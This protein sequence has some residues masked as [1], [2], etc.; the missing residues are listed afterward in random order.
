MFSNNLTAE[1]ISTSNQIEVPSVQSRGGD[2]PWETTGELSVGLVAVSLI[3]YVVK[4]WVRNQLEKQKAEH[5]AR[6]Q[7]LKAQQAERSSLIDELKL[8]NRVLMQEVISLQ[9]AI[10]RSGIPEDRES[11]VSK[12]S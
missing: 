2:F 3:G 1:N 5:N 9:G 4:E 6:L 8:Q 7:E 11:L 12:K 10:E